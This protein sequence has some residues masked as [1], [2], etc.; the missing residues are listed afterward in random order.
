MGEE[1]TE[2]L[3]RWKVISLIVPI[4][5]LLFLT[6]YYGFKSSRKFRSVHPIR[7][8]IVEAVYGLGTVKAE[9][10]YDLTVAFPIVLE[11]IYV[12][13]GMAVKQDQPL[14]KLQFRA[15]IPA[16]FDGI[17]SNLKLHSGEVATSREPILTLMDPR[18]RYVLVSLEQ[19]DALRVQDNQRAFLSFED[20][21]SRRFEGKVASLYPRAEE[22]LA[23]VDIQD[24]PAQV[25]P[26]MTL[27]VSIEIGR[28]QDALLV[29]AE[30]V[31]DK[32]VIVLRNGQKKN[33]P[34][35]MGLTD[36]EMVEIVSGDLN[37]SDSVLMP[38]K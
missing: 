2:W 36:Q 21:P 32:E 19:R 13:E 29:P 14:V 18:D 38:T 9:Q 22:F 11:K 16:P 28:K 33:V 7:G 35:S 3:S 30:A 6:I 34:V 27:N 37:V 24:L 12:T 23:K 26:G 20:D 25:L 1:K 15:T 17:I 8:E 10:V 5:L 31:D 4:I